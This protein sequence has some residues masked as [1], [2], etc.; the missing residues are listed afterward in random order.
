LYLA[1]D[2]KIMVLDT[3]MFSCLKKRTKM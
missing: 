2:G 3:K 1:K